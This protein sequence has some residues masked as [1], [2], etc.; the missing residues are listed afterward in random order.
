ML[1]YNWLSKA[2]R[3]GSWTM[4]WGFWLCVHHLLLQKKP[5]KANLT[6]HVQKAMWPSRV[7]EW[8]Y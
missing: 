3:N 8:P 7:E 6:S 4:F 2:S 1:K 5:G